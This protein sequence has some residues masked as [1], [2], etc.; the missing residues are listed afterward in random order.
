MPRPVML[1][2]LAALALGTV[3][4]AQVPDTTVRRDSARGSVE[5]VRLRPIE[6]RTSITPMVSPAI[7]SGVAASMATTDRAELDAWHARRVPDAVQRHAGIAAYDDLGAPGKLT[8]SA[9]GFTTGPTVGLPPGISVFLDG[10]RQNEA[11]AQ[12][13]NFDLLPM[14]HVKRVEVLTGTATLLGPNSMGGAINLVTERGE[15][16]PRAEVALGGGSFGAIDVD[17]SA[18]GVT[19]AGVDYFVAGAHQ[20]ESGWRDATAANGWNALVNVGRLGDVRG[21]SARLHAGQSRAETAGS[22]PESIF[23]VAPTTNFTAGDFEDVDVTQFAV[24]GYAPV[25][26]GNSSVTAFVRRSNAERFNVNQAP[27]P[28]VRGFTRNLSVGGTME[29][30]RAF[31]IGS[32]AVSLRAGADGAAQIARVRIFAE[33]SQQAPPPG[34]DDEPI[35]SGLTTHVRS[36]GADVAGY[37]LADVDLGRVTLSVGARGDWVRIPF[38]NVLDPAR[39]TVN[40]YTRLSPRASVHVDVGAGA[41]LYAS[42]GDGFRAPAILELGCAD[43]EAACPLPFALGDDPPLD[44]VLTRTWEIGGQ[45]LAG[46]VVARAAAYRSDVRDEIFFIASEEAALEGYFTNLP[47]TRR[48]GL[49]V[50]AQYTAANGRLSGFASYARTIAEFR[51]TAELFSIRSDDAA[52]GSPWEGENIVTAG[53]RLPLVP[54]HQVKAGGAFRLTRQLEAGVETRWIGRQWMRGD[55]T[56]DTE[57]LDAYTIVDARLGLTAGLWQIA[58]VVRNV[59]DE[60]AAVFGTFNENRQSGLVERFLTPAGARRLV[61]TV[62]RTIG[63]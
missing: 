17:A 1:L 6:V 14:A 26:R 51:T 27:D 32:R 23:G 15:A 24:T 60:R 10:V 34:P 54:D 9:R 53:D 22:L 11:D 12:E 63:G 45:W 59:L 48:A 16:A 46:P 50:S 5:P 61:V 38:R 29:W 30:R 49:E 35:D 40:R 55:E 58:G 2:V 20:R 25:A 39:D 37:L 57:P 44:P 18:S 33:P 52:A 21:I 13:V 43:P 3:V 56:N 41:S 28:D 7:G 4:H 31:T 62:R 19:R 47:R 8:I 36:T 42:M